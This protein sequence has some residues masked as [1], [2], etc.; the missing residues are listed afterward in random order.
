MHKITLDRTVDIYHVNKN[1]LTEL[2]D[3]LKE[4]KDVSNIVIQK[5]GRPNHWRVVV[6]AGNYNH[7]VR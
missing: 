4:D 3:I 7:I 6:G 1:E 5:M 2:L